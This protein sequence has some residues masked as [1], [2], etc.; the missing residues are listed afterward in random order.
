MTDED[1]IVPPTTVVVHPASEVGVAAA[2][3]G[4]AGVRAVCPSAA[5][6]ITAALGPDGRILVTPRV[7]WRDEYLVA[8]LAWVQSQSAGY[9]GFPLAEFRR[10][11]I[12]FAT[13]R[14]LHEVCAEHAIGLL[15]AMTRGLHRAGQN[16]VGREWSRVPADEVS[17]RTIVVLGLGT[18]GEGI[19]RRLSTWDARLVGVT[20]DP[21]RYHGGL[22]DVR[23]LSELARACAAASVLMVA[24]PDAPEVRGIVSAEILDALSPGW[25]VNVARGSLVDESALVE[26]L[27]DGRLLGAG[28][29]VVSTEPPPGDSP[30]WDLA[31]LVLTPHMAGRSPTYAVRFAALMAENLKAFHG[32]GEW[33]NRVC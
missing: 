29:D 15:L 10:R 6:D 5:D 23:P 13:G 24:L 22:T 26:R 19:A 9:E 7:G 18:I 20:R 3:A 2:L 32:R 4:L 27:R 30:L 16:R 1:Q 33:R 17:G 11:G 21:A 8:G 25:L 12:A 31:N 14:G 28:L